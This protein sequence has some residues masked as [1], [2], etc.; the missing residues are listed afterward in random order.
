M[1]YSRRTFKRQQGEVIDALLKKRVT[2]ILMKKGSSIV[3]NDTQEGPEG[4]MDE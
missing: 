4:R 3:I 2:F 1:G